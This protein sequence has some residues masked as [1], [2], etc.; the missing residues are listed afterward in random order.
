MASRVTIATCNRW[1][2]L[3]ASDHLYAEA[4]A[5]RRLTVRAAPWNGPGEPFA[6]ADAVVLRSN[7]DYHHEPEAFVA[8]L[9]RLQRGGTQVFNPV[10][11]V[12]WNLDKRYLLDL[13]A[14]GV[15]LPRMRVVAPEASAVMQVMAAAGWEQAV[16]KPAVGAS[17]HLVQLVRREA[18]AD[19]LDG[20]DPAAGR[21]YL[22]QEFIPEVRAGELA[23]VFFEGEFSHAFARVPPAEE[24]RVNSQYGGRTEA[25]EV[26]TMVVQQARVVLDALPQV[27]LYA[28]VDGVLRD[29]RFLLMELELNEPGLALDLVPGAADRFADATVRRLAQI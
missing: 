13:A 29:G 28:R 14:R 15:V 2:N 16:L 24:F 11:L 21:P 22:L 18:P 19:A 17:G 3:S 8:W 26:P 7:W 25:R 20:L 10:D 4:L 1:P 27:P 9:E 23:C 5:E 6:G 12:R